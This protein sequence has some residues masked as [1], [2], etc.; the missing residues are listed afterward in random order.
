MGE[1]EIALVYD[2]DSSLETDSE[3]K[4]LVLIRAIRL[5]SPL[6]GPA[7][8]S[9]PPPKRRAPR[10]PGETAWNALSAAFDE[11]GRGWDM[12]FAPFWLKR[13][14]FCLTIGSGTTRNECVFFPPLL[15]CFGFSRIGGLDW[16][17]GGLGWSPIYPYKARASIPQHQSKPPT[18]EKVIVSL[19]NNTAR[20]GPAN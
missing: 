6:L 5:A 8:H 15:C 1:R 19:E 18:R 20:R 3:S 7:E 10:Q 4:S 11:K 12:V 13:W 16:W 14:V 9:K 2:C 17:F